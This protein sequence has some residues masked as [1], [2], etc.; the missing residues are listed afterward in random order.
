[1]WRLTDDAFTNSATGLALMFLFHWIARWRAG[2]HKIQ[3]FLNA[4][5]QVQFF[6][7]CHLCSFRQLS[8]IC[9]SAVSSCEEIWTGSDTFVYLAA[10]RAAVG[11]RNRPQSSGTDLTLYHLEQNLCTR[12][13][14]WEYLSLRE[15]RAP[16]ES[17]ITV[18]L[19]AQLC[20][21]LGWFAKS[22]S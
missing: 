17:M 13:H 16:A 3:F 6:L 1:M 11:Q 22:S 10:Q 21:S 20:A 19:I 14:L 18:S 9:H 7:L 5:C 2:Q 15:W 4:L 12:K 8:S